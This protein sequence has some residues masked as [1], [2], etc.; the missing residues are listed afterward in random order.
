MTFCI[1]LVLWGLLVFFSNFNL[2]TNEV[3][4]IL[5]RKSFFY[6]KSL[7]YISEIRILLIFSWCLLVPFYQTVV[8]LWTIKKYYVSKSTFTSVNLYVVS[9]SKWK[10][11]QRVLFICVI[12]KKNCDCVLHVANLFLEWS[13]TF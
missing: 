3:L 9:W 11:L 8:N 10:Y 13:I 5:F 6:N 2:K 7:F 1:T 4:L 12:S